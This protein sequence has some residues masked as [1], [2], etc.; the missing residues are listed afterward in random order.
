MGSHRKCS[1]VGRSVACPTVSP[2][3]RDARRRPA[4]DRPIPELF[5]CRAL[6]S[7]SSQRL[8]ITGEIDLSGAPAL[9]RL[10]S[11]RI[12]AAAPGDRIRIDL[13]GVLFCAGGGVRA[14]V[15]AARQAHARGVALF[16]EPYSPA[17]ALA[18]DICGHL[19]LTVSTQAQAPATAEVTPLRCAG[20]ANG[21][22]GGPPA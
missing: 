10:L 15:A 14:L 7:G 21:S 20:P 8:V 12:A 1:I 16:Y 4:V 2:A 11:A 5:N 13:S 17:V 19:E 22:G 6:S 9:T 18:L 3:H